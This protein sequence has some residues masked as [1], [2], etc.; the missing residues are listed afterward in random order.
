MKL[1]IR[2]HSKLYFNVYDHSWYFY[3]IG[4]ILPHLYQGILEYYWHRIMHYGIFYR[5]FHKFHHFNQNPEPFDD[6]Y[7]HPI[8]A[9]GYYCI[10]FSPPLFIPMHL[11]SFIL[12]ML[13]CGITGVLDHSGIKA[14]FGFYN[15]SDHGMKLFIK[16]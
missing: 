7:I 1:I 16:T 5:N 8:E 11:H 6:M 14:K 4:L 15:S 9:F 13:I 3:F 2:G 12:Y 10:L